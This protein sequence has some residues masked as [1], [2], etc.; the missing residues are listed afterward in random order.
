MPKPEFKAWSM[1][2]ALKQ[3]KIEKVEYKKAIGN[4]QG[5]SIN[6]TFAINPLA[7][8]Q[9]KTILHELAHIVL[10][11]TKGVNA[12]HKGIKEFQAEST[13]Y[14]LAKELELKNWNDAESRAYIQDWLDGEKPQD[15]YIEQILTAV[16]K[17]LQAG[18][19]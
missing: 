5:Y 17:I 10:G 13:A 14:L 3:L 9:E 4:A 7:K 11:H 18:R 19:A 6:N 16:N 8:Y 12:E 1:E 15:K 2:Q